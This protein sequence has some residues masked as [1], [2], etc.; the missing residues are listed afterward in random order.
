VM[1]DDRLVIEVVDQ[2]LDAVADVHVNIQRQAHRR[3][4]G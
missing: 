2:T 3:L 1:A 4:R